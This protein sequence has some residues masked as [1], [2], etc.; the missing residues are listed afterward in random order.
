M[1]SK[2]IFVLNFYFATI[3]FSPHNTFIQFTSIREK[4]GRIRIKDL[5]LWLTDPDAGGS[6]TY[7]TDP[8][9]PEH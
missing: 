8:T 5:F 9:D 2:K 3:I 4:K 1:F 7:G 6:K